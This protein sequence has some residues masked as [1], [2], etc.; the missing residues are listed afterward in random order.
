MSIDFKIIGERIREARK[1]AG[2][3]QEELSEILDVTVGFISRME[4]G[5]TEVNLKRLGQIARILDI[6]LEEL[7]SGTTPD[8]EKYLDKDLAK[9]YENCDADQQKLIYNV[10]KIIAN[11]KL[12]WGANHFT[13]KKKCYKLH[14]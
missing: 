1:K 11:T 3:T 7:V 14:M 12:R 10:A 9:I 13:K 2:I 5:R 6:P 8:S 4:R